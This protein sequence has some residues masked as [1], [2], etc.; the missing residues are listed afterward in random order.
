MD[1]DVDAGLWVVPIIIV[2][3]IIP[4][5]VPAILVVLAISAAPSMPGVD[6]T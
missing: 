3:S 4:G 2:T 6:T 1:P 5:P